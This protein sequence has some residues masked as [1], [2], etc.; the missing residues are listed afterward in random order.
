MVAGVT[1][2]RY[3]IDVEVGADERDGL[4]LAV[5]AL[6]VLGTQVAGDEKAVA[7]RWAFITERARRQPRAIPAALELLRRLVDE[8]SDALDGGEAGPRTAARDQSSAA[9]GAA[10]A[11]IATDVRPPD[12]PAT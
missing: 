6:L 3:G 12:G 5:G 4:I 1:E 9:F 8:L 7:E 2:R 10:I 11:R